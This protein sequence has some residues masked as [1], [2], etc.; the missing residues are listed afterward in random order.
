METPSPPR[1]HTANLPVDQRWN[2]GQEALGVEAKEVL[3]QGRQTTS[4]EGQCGVVGEAVEYHR[5]DFNSTLT[6][7]LFFLISLLLCVC[8]PNTNTYAFG[9]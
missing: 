4:W 9:R 1:M 3:D 2:S 8:V 7:L 6:S 5:W